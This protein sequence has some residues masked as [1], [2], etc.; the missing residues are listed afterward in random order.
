MLKKFMAYVHLDGHYIMEDPRCPSEWKGSGCY[1]IDVSAMKDIEVE[2]WAE[3]EDQARKYA[4]DYEY[5]D[6]SS[7]VELDA[8]QVGLV[9]FVENLPDR[10]PEEVGVIDPGWLNWKY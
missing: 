2:V 6:I 10:D 1:D 5:R 9:K 3:T 8:V 4:L 7:T